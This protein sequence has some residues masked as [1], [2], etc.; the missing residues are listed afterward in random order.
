MQKRTNYP[1]QK[2][3]SIRQKKSKMIS[4]QGPS[5]VYNPVQCLVVVERNRGRVEDGGSRRIIGEKKREGDTALRME[6]QVSSH[7]TADEGKKNHKK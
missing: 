6:R 1:D 7:R 5:V 3:N 4:H 2:R